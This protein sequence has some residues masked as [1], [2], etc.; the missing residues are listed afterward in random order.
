MRPQPRVLPHI[1]GR[2]DERVAGERQRGHEKVDP[3]LLPG[4]RIGQLHRRPR[5]VDLD[6]LPGLV[7][8]PRRRPADQD[9][10]LIRL[11]ETVIAHRRRP[12]DAALVDVLAMEQL[13][14]HPDPGEL[15]MNRR[16]VRLRMHALILP[17]AREQTGIH[18]GLVQVGHI[19]PAD[20]LPV[21]GLDHRGQ[22]MT[23]HP[24]R[25]D[26]PA[27]EPLLAEPKHQLRFDLAY[28]PNHSFCRVIGHT[29]G[30]AYEPPHPALTDT[31][32]WRS[33][34]R[35]PVQAD[36][37]QPQYRWRSEDRILT[38]RMGTLFRPGGLRHLRA[39]LS[40][41]IP[42]LQVSR[43]TSSP[44]RGANRKAALTR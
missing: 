5:P 17:T 44:V 31:I 18:R 35:T 43:A 42:Q 8:D 3:P 36:G 40:R 10:L 27:R 4:H 39:V 38:R 11:A 41:R 29:A 14:R 25:G 37:A 7:T 19:V 16:P 23:R 21:G 34:P 1:Q 15:T 28:H 12:L 6:A 26:L 13:Q 33:T 30:G 24:L 2:L 20:T 32:R 22:A 9:V